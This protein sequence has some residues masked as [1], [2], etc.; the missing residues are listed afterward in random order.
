MLS[1]LL[2]F[3]FYYLPFVTLCRYLHIFIAFYILTCEYYY[4]SAKFYSFISYLK[5]ISARSK[6]IFSL[7]F[8]LKCVS[9]RL[10]ML[11]I[12]LETTLR[13]NVL[14][15]EHF[16]E[17]VQM[18]TRILCRLRRLCWKLHMF[19]LSFFIFLLLQPSTKPCTYLFTL[20]V[21]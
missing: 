16:Q 19:F 8:I 1:S 9:K 2:Y 6:C 14:P 18:P 13:G 12:A 10:L 5:M 21:N 4:L 11:F 7:I 20:T 17:T 3:G 15:I